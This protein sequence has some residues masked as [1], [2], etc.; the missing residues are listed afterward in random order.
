MAKVIIGI[1]GLCNKVKKDKLEEW[2]K[3]SIEEGLNIN[4][5]K[6]NSKFKFKMVYW[7]D[8][9][10]D[11]PLDE[12]IKDKKN[13]LYLDEPYLPREK[14]FSPEQSPVRK[15]V[16]DYLQQKL[17]NILLNDDLSSNYSLLTNKIVEKKFRDL[18][19]YY[20]NK[21]KRELIR[22]RLVSELKK[23]KKD[24]I[25]LITHSM[26]T[27]ISYEV[28]TFLC[29]EIKIDTLITIGSPLGFPLIKARIATEMNIK[30][31]ADMH[32]T[33]PDNISKYWFNL[34]DINDKVAMGYKL[35]N[36]YTANINN[37][38]V[39]DYQVHNDYKA[40]GERNY[41][42]S[43]GYLRTPELTNIVYKFIQTRRNP[44]INRIVTF[45]KKK[46]PALKK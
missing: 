36:D 15:K 22:E 45:F 29:P 16:L 24:D 28:L 19:T 40:N 30:N 38:S 25:L 3:K 5:D 37:V 46:F 4:L 10:Y 35:S 34:A 7:A 11:S 23:H 14:D 9:L 2:W 6:N 33:T 43:F 44:I 42:K 12:N 32:L 27:I 26:G 17:E 8:L 1:H 41:H 31:K 20:S 21:E 39:I 13:K 18:A